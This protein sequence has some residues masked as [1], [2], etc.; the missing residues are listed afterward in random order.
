MDAQK[1]VLITGA[2]RGIGLH[3]VAQYV[4]AGWNVIATARDPTNAGPLEALAP[5]KI[6]QLDTGDEESILRAAKQLEGT[7]IDLLINNAGIEEA[8]TFETATKAN[9][10]RAFEVNAVGTFLVTRALV[11]NLRLASKQRGS[12]VVANISSLLGSITVN[13][14]GSYT[15]LDTC[16]PE[17][18]AL[19]PGTG[20][21]YPYRTSKAAVNMITT[22]LASDLKSD[23]IIVV[24]I[25]PGLVKTEF[26][27]NRGLIPPEVSVANVFKR[28][29]TV[30]IADTAKFYDVTGPE[31]PW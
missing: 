28:L 18:H 30:T 25:Q 1:T 16:G 9:F 12:S 10:M 23:N 11:D 15:V 29:D 26:T 8:A 14:G 17:Y 21:R 5:A 6:V 22:S 13:A 3:F 2:T 27:G 19:K 31:L 20:S 4:K 7:P 24:A